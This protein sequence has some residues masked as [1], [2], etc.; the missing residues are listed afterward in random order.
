MN[1]Y[2]AT[3][4][5]DGTNYCGFQWQKDIATIQ[6]EINVALSTLVPGKITTM[7]A[8]R[9]DT[10]VHA[11]EQIVKITSEEEIDCTSFLDL[12]NQALPPEIFCLKIGLCLGSFNP[13]QFSSSKEY[14]YLFSNTLESRGIENKYIASYP[15]ELNI[16]AMQEAARLIVGTHDFKNFYSLGSNVKTTIREIMSCELT[17]VDPHSVLLNP[18]LF[19]ISQDLKM[20]YQLRIEGKGFLKHMVRNLMS[21]LWLVGREKISVDEFSQLLSGVTKKKRVWRVATP[22][23]LYLYRFTQN[24]LT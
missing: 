24:E 19:P 17:E 5:Y 18:E 1:Y 9:T 4:Q 8:S 3:V 12:F 16:K 20:C 23:G 7:S 6:N 2:K 22:R 11:L 10:G 13:T 14:R 15:Y 21:A